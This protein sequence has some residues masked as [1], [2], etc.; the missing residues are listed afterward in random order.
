MCVCIRKRAGLIELNIMMNFSGGIWKRQ[1]PEAKKYEGEEKEEE[2]LR[3]RMQE[4]EE[5]LRRLFFDEL[6]GHFKI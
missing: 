3:A 1:E 4:P 5:N 2:L 6:L